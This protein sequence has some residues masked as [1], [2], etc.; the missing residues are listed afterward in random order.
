[1]ARIYEIGYQFSH[2]SD[3][4]GNVISETIEFA[5]APTEDTD[6]YIRYEE[7]P[8]ADKYFDYHWS[9]EGDGYEVRLSQLSVLPYSN[10]MAEFQEELHIPSTYNGKP[11]VEISDF[12]L[13]YYQV[14]NNGMRDNYGAYV[15]G[16][17]YVPS[18]VKRIG[19]KAFAAFI[20]KVK[21]VFEED[22]VLEEISPDAFYSKFNSVK[23]EMTKTQLEGL[24]KELHER[25]I[26]DASRFELHFEPAE[27]FESE[28]ELGHYETYTEY[29]CIREESFDFKNISTFDISKIY[30]E[31]AHHYQFIAFEGLGEERYETLKIQPTQEEIEGWKTPYDKEDYETYWT[32]PLEIWARAFAEEWSGYYQG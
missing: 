19:E 23:V 1:L 15:Y 29:L 27:H 14:S 31:F 12:G 20:N 32:H 24:V 21:I 5:Y 25:Y 16:T 4:K 26:G 17:L 9:D 10:Y 3:A 6:L 18:S 2:I 28:G 30:H 8:V 11:V 22:A 7:K 13:S